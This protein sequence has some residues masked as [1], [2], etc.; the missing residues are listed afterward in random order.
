MNYEEALAPHSYCF[1]FLNS[2][3][4]FEYHRYQMSFKMHVID[5]KNPLQNYIWILEELKTHDA[6]DTADLAFDLLDL[7][8][9]VTVELNH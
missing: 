3:D 2:F 8:A 4:H 7:L 1:E 5:V 9:T 6:I